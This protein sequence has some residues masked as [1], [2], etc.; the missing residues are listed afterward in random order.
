[1]LTVIFMTG[2]FNITVIIE[3]Q[4]PILVYYSYAT[5]INCIPNCSTS[6]N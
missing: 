1:M 5:Y 4:E 6:R 3:H 2:A